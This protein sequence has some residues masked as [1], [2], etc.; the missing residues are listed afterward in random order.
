MKKI[1][2]GRQSIN[3]QDKKFVLKSLESNLITTGLNVTEF[4]K[5]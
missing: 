5:N 1:P 4:Q 3:N 2:Y